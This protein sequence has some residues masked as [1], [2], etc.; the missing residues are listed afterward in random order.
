MVSAANFASV[1]YPKFVGRFGEPAV[2]LTRRAEAG[3]SG[4]LPTER[5]D[6]RSGQRCRGPAKLPTN[7]G[8]GTLV[9]VLPA[10]P[11]DHP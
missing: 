8:Y 4:D 11:P 7:F 2:L 5:N 1:P 6:E 10:Q 3:R 9:L